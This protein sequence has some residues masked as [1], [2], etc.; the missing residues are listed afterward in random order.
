MRISREFKIGLFAVA[1]IAVAW[2]GIQWL[3]GE[4]ILRRS[5]VCY[6]YYQN[7]AGL[8]ESSRVT[9]RG[10]DIG[11]VGKITLGRDSVEV[12]L[13]IE[14]SYV[15]MI[16]DNSIAEICASGIMSG[17]EV[18]ILQGDSSDI[19]ASG[20]VLQGR[21]KPDML[22]A[23]TD[24]GTAL[25]EGMSQ[26]VESVNRLLAIN[27]EN[28]TSF[29]SNLERVGLSIS[30]IVEA[31]AGNIDNAMADIEQF[32]SALAESTDN[33]ERIVANFDAV[34]ADVAERDIVAKLSTSLDSLN[35]VLTAVSSGDGTASQLLADK[36]LYNSL[37]EAGSNLGA[38]LEDVKE[39]PA[40]Y[41]HFSLFGGAKKGDKR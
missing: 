31:T 38:L 37:T 41:V 15:D 20:S 35:G 19:I 22:G 26:T 14:R 23:L 1:V 3:G 9:M 18:A 25:M 30:S 28:L 34:T 7:I 11:N 33:I 17:V 21:V 10:V 24:K 32:T 27:S 12:V 36:Q 16:P 29:V 2:W 8:Q 4:N 39:N 5:N 40:R 13:N 6:V